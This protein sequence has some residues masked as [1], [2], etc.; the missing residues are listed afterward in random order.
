MG[1]EAVVIAD[2]AHMVQ[3]GGHYTELSP[4]AF[5]V[6]DQTY[7]KDIRAMPAYVTE[8]E[9]HEVIVADDAHDVLED[10]RMGSYAARQVE[11]HPTEARK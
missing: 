10:W 2:D 3:K 9:E 1:T 8:V 5:R 7:E 4:Q 11:S 6:P